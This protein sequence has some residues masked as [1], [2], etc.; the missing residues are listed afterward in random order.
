[1]VDVKRWQQNYQRQ[2]GGTAST[3]EGAPASGPRD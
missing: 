3:A 1:V 2:N